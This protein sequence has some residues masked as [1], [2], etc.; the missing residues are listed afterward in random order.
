MQQQQNNQE[1]DHG[2]KIHWLPTLNVLFAI[3]NSIQYKIAHTKIQKQNKHSSQ[4]GK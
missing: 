4:H 2:F 3:L 1:F